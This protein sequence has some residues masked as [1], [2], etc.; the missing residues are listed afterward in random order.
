[1]D[2]LELAQAMQEECAVTGTLS[3]V[4]T[5]VANHKRLVDWIN[6]AWNEIQTMHVDWD[7]MRSSVLTGDGCSF[8]TISGQ[9]VYPLGTGAGTVGILE[10][11][12]GK[13][14]EETCRDFA[15]T[16]TFLNETFV[17]SVGY[18]E[19]RDDYMLGANRSVTTRPN[20]VAVGPNKELCLGPPPTSAY[21][22]NID[23]FVAPTTMS[24]NTDTPTGL[25]ERYHMLIVYKAMKKYALY[26]SAG[27]VWES[28]NN[29][30]RPLYSALQKDYLPRV[31]FAGALA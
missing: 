29:E 3:D 4:T 23:Y 6:R 2:F 10:T 22:I 12:F 21:T 5:T 7:W 9:A 26:E 15:T 11:N 13:W 25:P 14:D 8:T 28:A 30:W 19:W 27:E 16:G 18:D 20:V 31:R 24:S 1:M 17:E